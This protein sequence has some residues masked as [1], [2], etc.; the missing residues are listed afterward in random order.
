MDIIPSHL[1]EK[2]FP[3]KVH[4]LMSPEER[5]ALWRKV[6]TVW[7]QPTADTIAELEK[8]RREWDS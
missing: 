3:K 4:P 7:K 5:R 1:T 6:Q 8:S 2:R